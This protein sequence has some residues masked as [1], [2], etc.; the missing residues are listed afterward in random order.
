VTTCN[1]AAVTWD[2]YLATERGIVF[3]HITG[4]D[5][6]P[7]Y[8]HQSNFADYNPALPETDPNQGG[9]LYPY[10]DNILG[11]YHS[12]Y[13][14]SA[15][16]T[17]LNSSDISAALTR[18]QAWAANVS[19]G[20]VSGY[21]LGDKMH[22]ITTV[23]MAVPVTGTSQGQD[24]AGTRSAWLAVT[25]GETILNL[26]SP[27]VNPTT[28]V[29]VVT[30]PAAPAPVA[31][32]R[33]TRAKTGPRPV[34]TKLKMSSRRF[35]AARKGLAKSRSHSQISWKLNRVSTVRLVIQRKM[36][37]KK[38]KKPTWLTMGAITKKNARVG[39]TK[40]NFTG[41]LGSRTVSKGSYRILA[42]ATA[43]GQRSVTKKLTFTVVKL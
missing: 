25:A 38:G 15:P 3:G 16:I 21:I 17:Q 1:A 35:A 32:K 33:V 24:Y 31:I 14:D 5:P 19:A 36:T 4:D 20:R 12:L 13:A 18:E 29:T 30:Q 22:I 26:K 2:Q 7:H 10:L 28:P 42:T 27:I 8:A 37:V 23:A 11:Y 34:L 39:T 41:K 43:G 9:I 40:V 6:R